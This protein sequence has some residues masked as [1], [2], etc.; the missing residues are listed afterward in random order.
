MGLP[1]NYRDPRTKNMPDKAY[2]KISPEKLYA[3]T[4]NQIMPINTLFQLMAEDN[5]DAKLMLFMPDLF[6]YALCGAKT[7]IKQSPPPRKCLI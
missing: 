3:A 2:E 6:A 5:N 7:Q 4:G 1:A